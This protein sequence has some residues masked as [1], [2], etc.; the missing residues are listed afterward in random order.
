MSCDNRHLHGRDLVTPQS[1][2]GTETD[3]RE[4][5]RQT[6]ID[7]APVP[8]TVSGRSLSLESPASVTSH[9][10][11]IDCLRQSSIQME[12]STF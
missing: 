4:L 10:I 9:R 12:V 6:E 3:C 11:I 8:T 2:S 7:L 1:L 5:H